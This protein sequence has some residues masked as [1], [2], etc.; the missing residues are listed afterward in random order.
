KAKHQADF[1]INAYY[2]AF[3]L[4]IFCSLIAFILAVFFIKETFCKSAVDFTC[5]TPKKIKNN[6][7]QH[8]VP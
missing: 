2:T 7:S 6:L 5:L 4:L 8:A 3:S 1:G